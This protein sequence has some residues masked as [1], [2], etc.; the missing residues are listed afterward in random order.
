MVSPPPL[1]I[2]WRRY[3]VTPL[4]EEL[5]APSPRSHL[6]EA[7]KRPKTTI[8][9]MMGGRFRRELDFVLR[10]SFV[11]VVDLF[12]VGNAFE[13]SKLKLIMLH[14]SDGKRNNSV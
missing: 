9:N 8:N 5:L 2:V 1:C 10:L 4:K 13:R 3:T 14:A 7:I 12:S 6:D 11:S